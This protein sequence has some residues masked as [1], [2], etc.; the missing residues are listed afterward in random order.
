MILELFCIIQVLMIL[1]ILCIVFESSEKQND[2]ETEDTLPEYRIDLPPN[3]DII[4]PPPD[5]IN[6]HVN[7]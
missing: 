7:S 5:Y 2:N 6:D 4:Y 3:Y 1:I